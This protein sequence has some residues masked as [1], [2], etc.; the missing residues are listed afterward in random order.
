M[1]DKISHRRNKA[2]RNQQT[3]TGICI[4]VSM[5]QNP[6]L[7]EGYVSIGTI[8]TTIKTFVKYLNLNFMPA[9]ITVYYSIYHSTYYSLQ[10]F[11]EKCNDN[12]GN[13][14]AALLM[15]ASGEPLYERRNWSLSVSA[16][17]LDDYKPGD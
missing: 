1:K 5:K 9:E 7:Y 8:V 10:Q 17:A 6:L 16:T 13:K 2:A 4:G 11:K 12:F 14:E 3:K 15:L